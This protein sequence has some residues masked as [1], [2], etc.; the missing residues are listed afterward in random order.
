ME[1][2]TKNA[3][4]IRL[5]DYDLVVIN[6]SAG[7]DSQAM[8]DSLVELADS[9][10]FPRERMIVVHADLGLKVEWPEVKALAAEQAAHYG[11]RIEYT[12]RIGGKATVSGKVYQAGET[13]GDLLDYVDRRKMWPSSK[14]RFCT[15][16]FKRG[17]IMRLINALCRELRSSGAVPASRPVRVLSC[18]GMRAQESAARA[19]R[20]PF[21]RKSSTSNVVVDEWLPI[22]AWTVEQVW[23][24]IRMSGVRH[25]WAYDRGMSRLSCMFCVFANASD[26]MVAGASNPELLREYVDLEAAIGHTFQAKKPL[27]NVLAALE[28][29][30]F[31]FTAPSAALFPREG[32]TVPCDEDGVNIEK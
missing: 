22:H 27:A 18:L 17:P 1:N 28:K 5:A 32:D 12:S 6:S 20:V 19:K 2:G 8:L 4:E 14:A 10:G 26:L 30:D 31:E 13:F 3:T 9:Q 7:K 21:N 24:R 15:S 11:L 23:D 16:E 25:H 29:R